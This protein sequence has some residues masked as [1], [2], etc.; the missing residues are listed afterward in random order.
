[1]TPKVLFNL[2]TNALRHTPPG[3][4]VTVAAAAAG[5]DLRVEILDS[6]PGIPAADLPHVF[7]RFWRADPSR[8]REHGGSG[9]GL[10]IARQMIEAQVRGGG[11][12]RGVE[13]LEHLP[14]GP[15]HRIMDPLHLFMGLL[16]WVE[17]P[18]TLLPRLLLLDPH[19]KKL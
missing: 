4:R 19:K 11:M 3:G 12:G 13:G 9:L 10:A 7:D 18:T 15:Q 2:L 5:G 17:H 1:L 16:A 8:S 14:Q 6:G